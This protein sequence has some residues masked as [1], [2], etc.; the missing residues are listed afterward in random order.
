MSIL[1][2]SDFKAPYLIAQV[3]QANVAAE[4]QEYID[5]YESSYL[6]ELLGPELHDIYI[7]NPNDY[8]SITD[9]TMYVDAYGQTEKHKGIKSGLIPYVYYFYLKGNETFTTGSGE[10]KID[11]GNSQTG[12]YKMVNAWNA[13]VH[14][15]AL[16]SGY[17]TTITSVLRPFNLLRPINSLNV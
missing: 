4:V 8:L 16:L 2:P 3:D 9:P 10:Q 5:T 7:A 13:M 14:E 15:T 12:M 1:T 6:N 17:V 11:K